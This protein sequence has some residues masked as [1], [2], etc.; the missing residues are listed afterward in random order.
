MLILG[1]RY[2]FTRFELRKMIKKFK[3]IKTIAYEG[4]EPTAIVTGKQIGR[5]HV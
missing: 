5:A 4:K 3:T 1:R 2:K